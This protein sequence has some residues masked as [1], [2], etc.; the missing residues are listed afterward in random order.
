MKYQAGRSSSSAA[1][2]DFNGDGHQDLAVISTS[3]VSVLLG[4]G[5][6]MFQTAISYDAGSV[7]TSVAVAD[8]NGDGRAD[9]AV[10]NRDRRNRLGGGEVSVLLGVGDGTFQPSVE[11]VTGSALGSWFVAVA[12]L[13]GDDKAD[14]V[15]A[16]HDFAG[17]D[18]DVSVRLGFGDGTFGPLAR[19]TT[20]N[21]ARSVAVGDF[22]RDGN[23]DLAV[24]DCGCTPSGKSFPGSVL[25]GTGDGRFRRSPGFSAQ[26][27]SGVAVEDFDGDGTSDLVTV[28]PREVTVLAG[29][30]NGAFQTAFSH[31]FEE[32]VSAIAVGE[33]NGDGKADVVFAQ[34]STNS[35]AVLLSGGVG[36]GVTLTA[37]PNPS[38]LGRQVTLTA[39]VVS[40]SGA[41]T[42]FVT[43]YA[44]TTVLGTAP[45]SADRAV[46]RTRLLPGGI[47]SLRAYYSGD[48]TH[49]AGFSPA[50]RHE[51]TTKPS[52]GFQSETSLGDEISFSSVTVGDFDADGNADLAVASTDEDA[53]SILR[54]SGNGTF[55]PTGDLDVGSSPSSLTSGDFNGDGNADLAAANSGSDNIS[56]LLGVGDGNFQTATNSAA[57]DSP[58]AISAG[59]FNSDGRLDLAVANLAADVSVVLGAGDGTFQPP[60]SYQTG[61]LPSSL[62]VGD[63]DGDA[64]PDLVVA[65]GRD[66]NVSVLLGIGD[67][68]FQGAA[69]YDV[70][71]TPSSVAVADFDGDG[72]LDIATANT[73]SEDV[74]VLLG[75]GDGTFGTAL[76]YPA[77]TAPS[78]VTVGD[79]DGNGRVD[80]A[81]ANFDSGEISVLS[82]DGDGA[83][84]SARSFG[85]GDGPNSMAS[86]E[87]DGDGKADLAVAGDGVTILLSGGSSAEV[88]LSVAPNPAILGQQVK[89]S[90]TVTG[91]SGPATG[92]ITF[93]DGT[94]VLGA[95]PIGV[96]GAELRTGLLAAGKRSL[97]AFYSGDANYGAKSSPMTAQTVTAGPGS[98]FLQAKAYTIGN[99]GMAPIGTPGLFLGNV[100]LGDF[101]GD[102]K[103]DL[104]VAGPGD[105]DFTL[106]FGVGDG[107]FPTS[108]T[109]GAGNGP[110]ALA[111]ADFNGDAKADLAVANFGDDNVSVFIGSGDGA[112]PTSAVF[113]T[114]MAPVSI[115]AS[116]FDG[117]G[118]A[119]LAV[120][121]LRSDDI[122]V[123]LGVGDGTFN[124]A[125]TY[126]AGGAPS[127]IAAGDFD[128]D[129]KPDLAI[130]NIGG[131]DVSV[132]VGAGDGTFQTAVSLS[133]GVAGFFVAAAD[134]NGDGRT[135]LA[136]A[137]PQSESVSVFLGSTG[138]TF[139]T[140]ASYLAGGAPSW[141]TVS[142][143]NGDGLADLGVTNFGD[144]KVGVLLGVGAGRFGTA[145]KYEVTA[146]P[147]A[148][149]T[150]DFNG[151][152]LADMVVG[153]LG[154][155]GSGSPQSSNVEVLLGTC[156]KTAAAPGGS[157]PWPRQTGCL[158]T[159]K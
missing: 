53:V 112:F 72:N 47:G 99:L 39:T 128:G 109:Y 3:S 34:S 155:D 77:G 136:V 93:Y 35:V 140:R 58:V 81:V 33:F 152:G 55:Q 4:L 84:Q 126:T 64:N 107:T 5:D 157:G 16:N 147:T 156:G 131:R 142:D 37:S 59:D 56:I 97:R 145:Q 124:S 87:F 14:L 88:R 61:M 82:G 137:I 36:T 41:R 138:G 29:N 67:G 20:G 125:A 26:L 46:L 149:G 91:P 15:N 134:L 104:V 54:G 144:N 101:N 43:F 68:Q 123:L 89:L 31:S 79:W 119:D 95:G 86:G 151:D 23:A 100:G 1:V 6:G 30:G 78:F 38:V 154:I 150:G 22:D 52:A 11:Y 27:S 49:R 18:G 98:G 50:V 44:G 85:V 122:S 135:D 48:A 32:F 71:Q 130:A 13:N 83:F 127:S 133:T 2:G 21:R 70:G 57:G 45:L 92:R 102:G 110:G 19:F 75:A 103:T 96:G 159:S 24:A 17:D 40:G 111:V 90:A 73:A 63:F 153:S 114:G 76:H 129:G 113:G 74:S 108:A 94:T 60:A 65:N 9:L 42:G 146:T 28:N 117:D 106:L 25:L 105:F 7:P 116:D 51:V 115:A 143:F 66:G 148:I 158:D 62:T 10:S 12:D 69:N 80:L 139:Q 120:A 141:V 118:N 8:F 132:L 121:N